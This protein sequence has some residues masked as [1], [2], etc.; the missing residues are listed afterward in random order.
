[1]VV[2]ALLICVA[3][4]TSFL[5]L[6]ASRLSVT[7]QAIAAFGLSAA[8]CLNAW[9]GYKLASKRPIAQH[10]IESYSRLD[11]RGWNPV[12]LAP[13]AGIGEEILFRGALQTL[14]GVWL[15]SALFVLAHTKAYR[16]N[17]LN[18]RV[19]FQ[20]AGLFAVSLVLGAIAHFTGLVVA[21]VV[22]TVIDIT[23]LYTVRHVTSRSLMPNNS[24]KPTPLRGAA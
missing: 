9:V 21:I 19:L 1:M 18:R 14:L 8:A 12:L 2:A 22:H 7:Q 10:T 5:S 3:T 20:A 13:A 17:G 6:F 23:G 11:L 15:S 4:G 16:F 24:S